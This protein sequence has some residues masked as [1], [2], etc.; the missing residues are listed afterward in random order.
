M[1]EDQAC[2]KGSSDAEIPWTALLTAW[3]LGGD[4]WAGVHVPIVDNACNFST[5]SEVFWQAFPK[6]AEGSQ[7]VA[8]SGCCS[9]VSLSGQ[10]S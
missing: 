4:K 8:V 2:S 10:M 1:S 3:R 5:I 9:C 6:E 7:G